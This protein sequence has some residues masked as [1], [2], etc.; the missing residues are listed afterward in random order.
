MCF[1]L[2]LMVMAG[3]P[4]GVD[5]P[6]EQAGISQEAAA[7]HLLQRFTNGPR[8]G[9]VERVVAMGLE[10]WFL[11]QLDDSLADP[12]LDARLASIKAVQT[13]VDQIP[14]RYP[15]VGRIYRE[16]KQRGIDLKG[17]GEEADRGVIG[18]YYRENGLHLPREMVADLMT[19]KI[20]RGRYAEAQ[21]REVLTDF[22]FN[23][24]Y[25]GITNNQAR[26]FVLD[27]ENQ[28]IRAHVTD[29]FETMLLASAKHPAMMLYLD[30]ATSTADA[31][32][33]TTMDMAMSNTPRRRNRGQGQQRKKGINENYARELLELHTVGVDGGYTQKDITE[34]AR[35]L[36]GWSVYPVDRANM[37]RRLERGKRVGFMREGMF[38]FRADV[39]DAGPKQVMH[40]RFPKGGGLQEG[41]RAIRELSRLPATAR[42]VTGKFARRFVS[43]K[44]PASLL[45]R[46]EA[47]WI[48]SRGDLRALTLTLV[49]SPE[50]WA[51]E[52]RAVRMKSPF[53]LAMSAMRAVDAEV[54]TVR[55]LN[56][57]LEEM[58]QPLYRY[59]A[60]TGFP[61]TTAHWINTGSMSNRLRFV[62]ALM[63]GDIAGV[64]LNT[65]TLPQKPEALAAMLLPG[66]DNGKLLEQLGKVDPGQL[67]EGPGDVSRKLLASYGLLEEYK[68]SEQPLDGTAYAAL[69][70]GSPAYQRY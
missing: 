22:W 15:N 7:L 21:V 60:P 16:A 48:A 29:T 68:K 18:R 34:L 62:T 55:G 19:Q 40:L 27:Y 57:A 53:Q 10:R 42:F 11:Q 50:F 30:L 51:V 33:T 28:V 12:K 44:P 63:R 17:E 54:R 66:Q 23:H 49:Q 52:H 25:V 43:E 45:K 32:A 13:P 4:S 2:L 36:T 31:K 6:Y 8:P 65:A 1:L 38:L 64:T 47:N 41:E 39:H 37:S 70:M 59:P 67:Q 69:I 26:N 5:F 3:G 35:V 9:D 14:R 20:V 58:G 24:L 46:L 61:D 56:K